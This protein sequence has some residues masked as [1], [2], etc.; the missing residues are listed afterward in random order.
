LSLNTINRGDFI[1]RKIE[2]D[3]QSSVNQGR[4][5]ARGNLANTI[6]DDKK[7]LT[8]P[9]FNNKKIDWVIASSQ[10][11]HQLKEYTPREIAIT[12]DVNNTLEELDSIFSFASALKVDNIACSYLEPETFFNYSLPDVKYAEL[13]DIEQAKVI[14]IIGDVFSKIPLLAKPVLDAKFR[15]R[16]NRLYYI[17]SV[18]GR[19]AGFANKSLLVKPGTEPLLLL[20]LIGIIGKTTKNIIGEKNYRAVRKAIPSIVEVCGV[21]ESEIEEVA[22][23]ITSLSN[24]VILAS[25]DFGKTDDPLLFSALAQLLQIVL[26]DDKKFCAPALISL[27]IGKTKFGELLNSVNQGKVKTIINFGDIFP[28][29]YPAVISNLQNLKF[30]VSTSTMLHNLTHPNWVLPVPSLLEKSG[31]IKTLWGKA[32][33]KPLAEPVNGS[34]NISEIIAKLD[35]D[36]ELTSRPRINDKQMLNIDEIIER[37]INFLETKKAS[38][39]ELTVLGEESAFNYRGIL[40]EKENIIKIN[41]VNAKQFVLKDN[42]SVKLFTSTA[43]RVFTANITNAVS[44]NAVSV[45]TDTKENRALFPIQIDPMTNDTIISPA[46]GKLVKVA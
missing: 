41:P 18:K 13:K 5:C 37:A 17:D 21:S 35:P 8:S 2:Y 26:P 36:I 1:I 40:Q 45:N 12:F 28:D 29:Y 14:L 3:S 34:K 9:L 15:D 20:A 39:N 22:K 27:P 46:K 30:F 44:I 25:V 16:N 43:E 24:G 7:R 19:I 42:D 32:N 33:I 4:L 23:S 38:N 6:I 11:S 31:S 10:I